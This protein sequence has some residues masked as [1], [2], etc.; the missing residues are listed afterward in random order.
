MTNDEL[1]NIQLGDK[2]L[3]NNSIYVIDALYLCNNNLIEYQI[4]RH[5]VVSPASFRLGDLAIR[6]T[7]L[8]EE[9]YKVFVHLFDDATYLLLGKENKNLQ[10]ISIVETTMAKDELDKVP[11][12]YIHKVEILNNAI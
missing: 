4:S 9:Q 2:I 3:M 10:A 6:L 12:S 11:A 1:K 7:T 5:D 8:Y